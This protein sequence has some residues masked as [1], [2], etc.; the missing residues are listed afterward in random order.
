MK[1]LD[2]VE[3]MRLFVRIAESGSLWTAAQSVGVSWPAASHQL[4]QVKSLLGVKLV[5]RSTYDLGLTDAGTRF[6]S[7][8]RQT[9]KG[10]PSGRPAPISQESVVAA[11]ARNT[12][13]LRLIE[14][15]I[16]LLAAWIDR[17]PPK[18]K[19]TRSNRV[20]CATQNKKLRTLYN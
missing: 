9:A 16:P 8:H 4:R 15:A 7:R 14:R 17:C 13:F 10:D 18:A 2:R 19:V 5:R 20:G 12:R 11:G 6:L 3:F 1:T